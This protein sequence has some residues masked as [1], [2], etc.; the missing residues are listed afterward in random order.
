LRLDKDRAKADVAKDV[1]GFANAQ[2]GLILF[3]VSE[4]DSDDPRPSAVVPF[5]AEGLQTRLENVLDSTLESIPDYQAATV[6]AGSGSV[7][8]VR[9]APHPGPPIMVQGYGENRFYTRSGTR[10]RPMSATEV[11]SAHAKAVSREARLEDRLR[12]LPLGARIFRDRSV[13]ALRLGREV[14]WTPMVAVVM[15]ALDGPDELVAPNLIARHAFEERREGYRGTARGG[16]AVRPGLNWTITAHGLVDER[17]DPDDPDRILHRCAVHRLGVVEWACRYWRDPYPLPSS[18]LADDVHNVLLYGARVFD[19]LG[20]NGRLATWVRIENA[21]RAELMLARD[22]DVS[23]RLPGVQFLNAYREV[24]VDELLVDRTA[25]VRE[26]MDR[27]WQG[28]GIQR[29]GL[30]EPDGDW[31]QP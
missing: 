26:A 16:A 12:Q 1:S 24:S 10:T 8:L 27:I 15:A 19:R 13:D 2:G 25:T 31:R 21:E 7:I 6:D 17:H 5:P 29:C 30:F 14:E 23:T 11:A 20:Y 3:G 28:F 22:W 18:S 9:V 4:D